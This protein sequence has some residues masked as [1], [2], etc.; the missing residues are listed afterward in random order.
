M[1]RSLKNILNKHLNDKAVNPDIEYVEGL[2][3]VILEKASKQN[4]RVYNK[5]N[6]LRF[7]MFKI[8]PLLSI[9][10]II[11][12]SVLYT[13]SNKNEENQNT[14]FALENVR[15]K[16]E[17]L[18]NPNIIVHEKKIRTQYLSFLEGNKESRMITSELWVDNN[19]NM[20]RSDE[21]TGYEDYLTVLDQDD[22]MW[23]FHYCC[24]EKISIKKTRF[25]NREISDPN[26]KNGQEIMSVNQVDTFLNSTNY[27]LYRDDNNQAI[28]RV[29]NMEN[30]PI[31]LQEKIKAEYSFDLYY[32]NKT[33]LLL[34]KVETY[35]NINGKDKLMFSDSIELEILPKTQENL[36][37]FF[38]FD[39]ELSPDIKISS[40]T[41]DFN[42]G[43]YS[44]P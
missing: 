8:L 23:V 44:V 1:D 35:Y 36:K 14:V 25:L 27:I 26:Y 43:E 30:Q 32:Y 5:F 38:T 37:G 41:F 9:T 40:E 33:S 6:L 7:L 12:I 19:S 21:K 22:V 20:F 17:E 10:A 16:Y 3:K 2:R 13:Q 42:T 31:N 11:L 18:K 28:Y 15:S 24:G 34:D 29:D 4:K 39:V